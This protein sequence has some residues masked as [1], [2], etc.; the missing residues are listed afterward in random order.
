MLKCVVEIVVSFI[1][2]LS[3]VSTLSSFE[4]CRPFFC[5]TKRG[6]CSGVS[7]TPVGR[8]LVGHSRLNAFHLPQFQIRRIENCLQS[9]WN[10][11]NL[12]WRVYEIAKCRILIGGELLM[13]IC[14]HPDLAGGF[15]SEKDLCDQIWIKT[16]DIDFCCL[17]V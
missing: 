2:S 10:R 13:S 8:K 9:S 12:I 1:L 3:H 14:G 11:L 4:Q 16:Q 15:S 17:W 7:L 6:G 5:L